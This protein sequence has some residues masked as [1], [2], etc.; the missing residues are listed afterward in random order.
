MNAR[1]QVEHPVTEMRYGDLDLVEAQLRV[2]CGEPLDADWPESGPSGHAIEFR[3]NAEDP[4]HGFRPSPGRVEALRIPADANGAT[5]RWDSGLRSGSRV[6][7]HYDSMIGKLIVHADDRDQ[8]LDAAAKVL[9]EAEIRGVATT[10]GLHRRIL[11]HGAFR[12][13]QL[14]VRALDRWLDEGL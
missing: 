10:I 9:A 13:G 11:E 3:I 8:A 14:D 2:A 4:D 1:L 12:A 5:V 7:P 6:P